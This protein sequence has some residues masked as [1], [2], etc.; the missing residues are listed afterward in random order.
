MVDEL[1]SLVGLATGG[2]V[3]VGSGNCDWIRV[4]GLWI[5]VCKA[6]AYSW[7]VVRIVTGYGWTGWE[8]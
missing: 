4:D 2:L 3:G 8:A 6:T 5:V 1:D 7:S